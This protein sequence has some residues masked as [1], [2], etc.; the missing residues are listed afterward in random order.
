MHDRAQ[1]LPPLLLAKPKNVRA[2]GSVRVV[3]PYAPRRSHPKVWTPQTASL[4]EAMTDRIV[5]TAP[6]APCLAPGHLS[7]LDHGR[8]PLLLV[9]VPAEAVRRSSKLS[10]VELIGGLKRSG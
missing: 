9:Y 5:G 6:D 1:R 2:R 3:T 8:L 7:I 4:V 10:I